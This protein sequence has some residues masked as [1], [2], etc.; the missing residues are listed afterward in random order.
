MVALDPVL[1]WHATVCKASGAPQ[2]I[3]VLALLS[4]TDCKCREAR[5]VQPCKMPQPATHRAP[6]VASREI[7]GPA[8]H[9][10]PQKGPHGAASSPYLPKHT[11]P[12]VSTSHLGTAMASLVLPTLAMAQVP[13][14]YPVPSSQGCPPHIPTCLVGANIFRHK[15][16]KT[17]WR[18]RWTQGAGGVFICWRQIFTPNLTADIAPWSTY[19]SVQ[20]NT[21]P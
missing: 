6:A 9:L 13:P 8:S 1:P 17:A 14:S 3:T 11:Q 2:F 16:R 21:S 10:Y 7:W 18:G 4:L 12:Q 20:Y 15:N 5:R 19:I